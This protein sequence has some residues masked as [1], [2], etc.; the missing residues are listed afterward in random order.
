MTP[1]QRQQFNTFLF[2][3]MSSYCIC[4]NPKL[5]WTIVIYPI[6]TTLLFGNYQAPLNLALKIG[7]RTRDISGISEIK[8]TD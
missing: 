8:K 7:R 6:F 1:L 3:I 5:L 2:F 4:E